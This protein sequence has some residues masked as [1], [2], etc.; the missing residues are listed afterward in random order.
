MGTRT[1]SEGS[2]AGRALRKAALAIVSAVVAMVGFFLLFFVFLPTPVSYHVTERY[3][4][5]AHDHDAPVRLAVILPKTGPYQKVTGVRVSWDGTCVTNQHPELDVLQLVGSVRARQTN[6]AVIQYTAR[7]WQGRARW[8]GEVKESQRSSEPG[9]ESDNPALAERARRL[10]RRG[11]DRGRHVG[12]ADLRGQRRR[13]R[14]LRPA[15]S[16]S[17][18]G[19]L[20]LALAGNPHL[21]CPE[22]GQGLACAPACFTCR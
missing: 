5:A 13:G 4:F 18:L 1:N 21:C 17:A 2:S 15:A 9:I 3:S 6:V 20:G 11:Q 14:R 10:A 22:P 7:M 8:N 19:F 16:A 12:S